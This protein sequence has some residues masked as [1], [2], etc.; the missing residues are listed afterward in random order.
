MGNSAS[1]ASSPPSRAI[2]GASPAQSPGVPH[3]SL[4]TKK[5][6]LELPDLASLSLG[7]S[8]RGRQ[9][10]SASIPI[11]ISA[12]N[13]FRHY[14]QCQHPQPQHPSPRASRH[15]PSTADVNLVPSYPTLPRPNSAA[16]RDRQQQQQVAR[17]QELYNH[18]QQPTHSPSHHRSFQQETVRSS[19]PVAL[20]KALPNELSP[21]E[22]IVQQE[23]LQKEDLLA[24]FVPVKIIWKG[25][26]TQVLL[27][28]ASDGRQSME[29]ELLI[30]LLSF[31][32]FSH[33]DIL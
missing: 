1:N 27:A 30:F 6:S 22:E 11:P 12:P 3:P 32:G 19:I 20:S 16:P 25:G 17:M 4:R 5:K 7:D 15:L 33:S 13:P 8:T 23:H 26:G 10:K 2:R 28:R 9:A 24:D 31:F 14:Q 29:K 21:A 18:S